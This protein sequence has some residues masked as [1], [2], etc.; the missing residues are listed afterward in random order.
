MPDPIVP[1]LVVAPVAPA[2]DLP[3]GWRTSELWLS[4][5]GLGLLSTLIA[6]VISALPSL[7]ANPSVPAWAAPLLV[8]AVTPLGY[9]AKRIIVEYNKGRVALKLPVADVTAA[10]AAGAAAANATNDR[11]L[12]ALNK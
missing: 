10:V 11:V 5:A 12:I 6:F 1:V 4:T 7:A 2:S 3:A 9:L 8:L